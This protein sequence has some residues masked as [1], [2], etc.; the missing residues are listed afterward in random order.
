MFALPQQLIQ[1]LFFYAIAVSF[2][3]NQP[4]EASKKI[5][6]S[7]FIHFKKHLKTSPKEIVR[8]IPHHYSTRTTGYCVSIQM[9]SSSLSSSTNDGSRSEPMA[10]ASSTANTL[11]FL[12]QICGKLKKIKRTGW[13]R[14]NIP[15]PESDADH[16][17]RCAMCAMLVTAQ[18]PHPND[19]Y[20]GENLKFH[21]DQVDGVKLLRMAVT[22]DLCEAIAGDIT[23]FC[24]VDQVATKHENEEKAMLDIKHIVGDTLGLELYNLW[25]EYEE[26]TSIE[27]LYCKDIDKFEMVMQ[28]FEYETDHLI[29]RNANNKRG[30]DD[31]TCHDDGDE[32][33]N[34]KRKLNETKEQEG[35]SVPSPPL[36]DGGGVIGDPLRSF[37]ITTNDKM[38]SPLFRRLDAELR[39]KREILLNQRGWEVTNEEQQ[40]YED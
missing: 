14:H 32:D 31:E 34:K 27:A 24:H 28:A 4:V 22:H 7:F 20:I 40:Q 13:V 11:T 15:L 10:S 17:H 37:Y 36:I 8:A 39:Q 18:P 1:L 16:M 5:E 26:Q 23:P 6:E 2:L 9:P 30:D 19:D 3:S 25:K 38:K 35:T 12:S 29:D 21:P 33:T